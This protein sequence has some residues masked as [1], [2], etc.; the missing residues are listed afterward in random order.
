MGKENGS[1]TSTRLILSIFLQAPKNRF[2]PFFNFQSCLPQNAHKKPTVDWLQRHLSAAA[3]SISPTHRSRS[4]NGAYRRH[5]AGSSRARTTPA[6]DVD[7]KVVSFGFLLFLYI[8]FISRF[9]WPEAA[10][11][12]EG[13]PQFMR[14]EM[15]QVPQQQQIQQGSSNRMAASI[16]KQFHLRSIPQKMQ[17]IAVGPVNSNARQ[18]NHRPGSS[19]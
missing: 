6:V 2:I 1:I 10:A 9:F 7:Q 14:L 19:P 5:F 17:L 15:H 13:N 18:L 12:V 3:A 8:F 16:K 4:S 11:A